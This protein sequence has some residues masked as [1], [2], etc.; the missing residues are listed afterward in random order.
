[1]V[2]EKGRDISILRLRIDSRLEDVAL[3]GY[4]VRGVCQ[5]KG[6]SANDTDDVE[7]AVCESV[8]NVVRHGPACRSGENV[9]VMVRAEE[10][11]LVV[12]IMDCA[13]PDEPNEP[14]EPTSVDCLPEGG[15]GIYLI[16]SLMD[17]VEHLEHVG[18]IVLRMT[19][20]YR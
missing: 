18:R 15:F 9:E 8:N 1:M 16:H 4:A 17:R 10:R 19:K 11:Q 13:G 12:E 20:Q 14:R 3:I 5:G 6:M 2:S 7:L